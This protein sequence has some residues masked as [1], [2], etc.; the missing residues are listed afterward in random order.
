MVE[1][2]FIHGIEEREEGGVIT[3]QVEQTS[4]FV[5][6]EVSDDGE[7]I[8]PEKIEQLLSL[9][10]I[11]DDPIGHSTGI[12]LTNVIR[13]LQLFYKKSDVVEIESEKGYWTTVRLLL[14]KTIEEEHR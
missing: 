1:N 12:G 14:P 7:G 6:V 11:S 9:G 3:I 2:A 4:K 8:E 13:R 5:I 10:G